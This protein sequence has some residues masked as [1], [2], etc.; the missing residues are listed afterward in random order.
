MFLGSICCLRI[1]SSN[2]VR[3]CVRRGRR[4]CSKIVYGCGCCNTFGSLEVWYREKGLGQRDMCIEWRD[5]S[6][7]NLYG[8]GTRVLLYA[9]WLYY[10]DNRPFRFNSSIATRGHGT[11]EPQGPRYQCSKTSLPL[12]SVHSD[13]VTWASYGW[14]RQHMLRPCESHYINTVYDNMSRKILCFTN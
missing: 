6:E 3:S 8:K 13:L 10:I 5:D 2:G 7:G 9:S 1:C 12:I 14:T 4:R 11:V